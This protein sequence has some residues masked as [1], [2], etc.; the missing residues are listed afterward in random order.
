MPRPRLPD[1]AREGKAPFSFRFS[2]YR[3]GYFSKELVTKTK[4]VLTAQ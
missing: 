1:T 2:R 3:G 4:P